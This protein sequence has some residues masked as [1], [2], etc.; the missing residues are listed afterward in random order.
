MANTLH[1]S[2]NEFSWLLLMECMCLWTQP[3]SQYGGLVHGS[4]PAL[5]QW[6]LVLAGTILIL[7]TELLLSL[8]LITWSH[9]RLLLNHCVH[10]F[11][12]CGT[13]VKLETTTTTTTTTTKQHLCDSNPAASGF[14]CHSH[15]GP[16]PQALHNPSYICCMVVLSPIPE[17]PTIRIPSGIKQDISLSIEK[18]YQVQWLHYRWL[19]W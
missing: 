18:S 6:G 12:S 9:V 1:S 13:T 3:T 4:Y 8:F 14:I 7:I 19:P 16:Q 11:F 10:C 17:Q 15:W 5:W 2:V